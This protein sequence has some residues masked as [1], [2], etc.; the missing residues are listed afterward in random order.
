MNKPLR[1]ILIDDD[2]FALEFATKTIQRHNRRAEVIAF[3]SAQ[4]GMEFL[5]DDETLGSETDTVLLTDLHMPGMDGFAVLEQ[6]ENMPGDLR[7]GLHIFVL[8]A[9][10][11]PDEIRMVLSYRCVIGFYSKPLSIDNVNEIVECV[12]YPL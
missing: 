3:S 5:K 12:Q 9:D 10:A 1:F 8:S 11:N 2:I 4:K 7:K 6:M